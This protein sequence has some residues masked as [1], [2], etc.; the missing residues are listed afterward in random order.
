MLKDVVI[1][2]LDGVLYD[3][4]Q[5]MCEYLQNRWNLNI[6]VAQIVDYNVFKL[7]DDKVIQEDL[8]RWMKDPKT[9]FPKRIAVLP[10]AKLAIRML[11]ECGY[12]V[13]ACTSRP[14]VAKRNTLL[15]I[16]MDFPEVEGVHFTKVK[17]KIA[18]MY[19]AR[20]FIEDNPKMIETLSKNRIHTFCVR[21]NYNDLSHI[22]KFRRFISEVDSAY[23]AA[24]IICQ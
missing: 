13:Y 23:E 2:D 20:Y 10:K 21:N 6:T 24:Q 17:Q 19:G 16:A 7:T 8:K 4:M 18:K 14:S 3:T 9:Y 1:T 22:T 12:A 15:A 5:S 11:K